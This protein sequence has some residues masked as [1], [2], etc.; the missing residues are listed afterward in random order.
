MVATFRPTEV[1]ANDRVGKQYCPGPREFGERGQE[2]V[3][4][5][6]SDARGPVRLMEV[7]VTGVA[8]GLLML[9]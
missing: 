8:P 3:F 1:G 4:R 6:N 7:I 9:R 2:L 5:I